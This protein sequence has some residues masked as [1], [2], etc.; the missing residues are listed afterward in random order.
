MAS[1]PVTKPSPGP[2]PPLQEE[3]EKIEEP[4]PRALASLHLT[5]HARRLIAMNQPDEAIRTLE[6][7]LNLDPG[8][9]KNYYYLAEAWIQKGNRGHAAEFNRLAGIYLKN[10]A[11]WLRMVGRQKERIEDSI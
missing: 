7:A 2:A 10:D 11:A 5:E 9:G 3:V 8:N 6:R 1:I 4:S